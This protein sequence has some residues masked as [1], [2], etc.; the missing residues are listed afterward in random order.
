MGGFTA[1][2][3]PYRLSY[4]YPVLLE[5]HVVNDVFFI[6]F[7]PSW[8]AAFQR[9]FSQQNGNRISQPRLG[10]SCIPIIHLVWLEKD[11]LQYLQYS[12]IQIWTHVLQQIFLLARIP[13][14][15][16]TWTQGRLLMQPATLH[17]GAGDLQ[18]FEQSSR[19]A[20]QQKCGSPSMSWRQSHTPGGVFSCL[21]ARE[22]WLSF[23]ASIVSNYQHMCDGVYVI[24]CI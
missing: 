20:A 22:S 10:C 16:K 9:V 3:K 7:R 2:W 4:H 18:M 6:W 15:K 8:S 13:P 11:L 5:L 17:G 1:W 24:V 19:L 23:K 14:Q 12:Y 21:G